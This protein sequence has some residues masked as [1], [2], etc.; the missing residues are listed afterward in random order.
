MVT[1]KANSLVA[2]LI[3]ETLSHLLP[4]TGEVSST[5][6]LLSTS[7]FHIQYIFKFIHAIALYFHEKF[8]LALSQQNF[9]KK[10]YV[11]TNASVLTK[12][13]LSTQGE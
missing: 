3:S 6:G 11:P 4:G 12:L 9:I 10:G 2:T 8:Y 5:A 13:A 7:A 1:V